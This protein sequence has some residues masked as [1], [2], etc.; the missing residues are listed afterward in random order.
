VKLVYVTS[1]YPYGPGEA[2]LG[3]EIR[4]HLD[5]GAELVVFP[6]Y[7][8]GAVTHADAR[9]LLVR[10]ERP[11]RGLDARALGSQVLA[12]P[13]RLSHAVATVAARQGSRVRAKNAA[14]LTRLGRLVSVLER[15]RPDH[16]HAHWGGTS[17][18]LAMAAA[19]VSR[20]PWSLTLHRWD[21]Y[22]N[23]LLATKIAS[24]RFTR[25]ISESAREDVRR[26]VPAAEPRVLHMG[27]E[28]PPAVAR[29]S[30]PDG[31]V[32]LVCV[33][34]LVPVKDHA[35]LLRAFAESGVDATLELVGGGPLEQ[36]LRDRAT[37][38]GIAESVV[39]SGL[40]P[41]EGLLE[42]LRAGD[43]DA[44]VLASGSSG[45]EHEGIPVS[46]MEAMAAGVPAVATASGGT[47]ELVTPDAGLLVPP[48]DIAAL[49]SA[50]QALVGD[51]SLRAR[52]AAGARA[53]VAEA[54]DVRRVASELRA[55]MAADA[56]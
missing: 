46:L 9:E 39:F 43:W 7:P 12:R 29:A 3:P 28:V 38:L 49:G 56:P 24:A 42:R 33:A 27:V 1:R 17:S 20:V 22:E 25:V 55:L 15:V 14:V 52:L 2:F 18:T 35:T 32:R 19:E 21:I 40:L 31:P 53:R 44:I 13:R 4:A 10:T 26:I 37:S 16:V 30:R 50:L 45:T 6:A 34:S 51:A 36:E 23:N 48:G 8:H 54:F 47:R 5:A 41:H 11:A